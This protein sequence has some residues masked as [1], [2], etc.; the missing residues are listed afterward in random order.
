MVYKH[1]YLCIIHRGRQIEKCQNFLF[2]DFFCILRGVVT[3][4]CSPVYITRVVMRDAVP[5][6]HIKEVAFVVL[7]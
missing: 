2:F 3:N 1:A 7:E 5:M 6:L 4:F